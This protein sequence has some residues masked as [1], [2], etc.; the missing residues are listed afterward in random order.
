MTPKTNL[1]AA[2]SATLVAGCGGGSSSS[3]DPVTRHRRV[4]L[5]ELSG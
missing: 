4:T 3:G 2:A 5:A 1:A